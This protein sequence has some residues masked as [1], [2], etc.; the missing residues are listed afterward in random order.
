[1]LNL[2]SD[3]HIHEYISSFLLK[4]N[5]IYVH[6]ALGIVFF[7]YS[8][9]MTY[10]P[11]YCIHNLTLVRFPFLFFDTFNCNRFC[12]DNS[13]RK[14]GLLF[15]AKKYWVIRFL[16]C[17]FWNMARYFVKLPVQKLCY[18]E[19]ISFTVR[20]FDIIFLQNFPYQIQN[21]VSHKYLI[22]LIN[23]LLCWLYGVLYNTQP[24][25]AVLVLQFMFLDTTMHAALA[26]V[27]LDLKKGKK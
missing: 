13:T 11:R 12:F 6:L 7:L 15:S 5:W 24:V 17:F 8:W 1:M 14:H 9:S 10:P 16:K 22:T 26:L 27:T 23:L 21:N 2:S 18:A 19:V 20:L 3:F 4:M 25:Q